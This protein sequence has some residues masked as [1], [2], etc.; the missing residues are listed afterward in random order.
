MALHPVIQ[1]SLAAAQGLPAYYDLPIAEARLQAKMG[2]PVNPAPVPVGAVRDIQ[3]AGPG[4]PITVR[5]YTPAITNGERA[6]CDSVTSANSESLRHDAA[7]L[8]EMVANQKGTQC[9]FGTN[10]TTGPRNEWGSQSTLQLGSIAGPAS[11]NPTYQ[12]TRSLRVGFGAAGVVNYYSC[13]LRATDGSS[14]NCD[15]AGTGTYAIEA[16]GDAR[17]MRF[18]NLPASAAA[19]TYNRNFVE[20]GGKVYYGFRDK[21]RVNNSVRTNL[22]ATDAL[23]GA[24]GLAR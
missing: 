9:V 14:R 15:P 5:L 11:T 2:Y 13:A 7:N 4:G 23:L 12:S 1:A 10:A 20:R 19:L 17:V 24:L 16:V 8:E 6:G 22:Q 21:L 3:L 18:A